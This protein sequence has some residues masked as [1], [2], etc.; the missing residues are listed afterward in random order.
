MVVRPFRLVQTSVSQRVTYRVFYANLSPLNSENFDGSATRRPP[1]SLAMLGNAVHTL[2]VTWRLADKHAKRIRRVWKN[3]APIRSLLNECIQSIVV[4]RVSIALIDIL[5]PRNCME[6]S[7]RRSL[8]YKKS[9]PNSIAA[10][11]EQLQFK[12]PAIG[13]RK[14][15]YRAARKYMPATAFHIL[16]PI[17]RNQTKLKLTNQRHAAYPVTIDGPSNFTPLPC[18]SWTLPTTSRPSI[19][20]ART[21]PR[22][23]SNQREKNNT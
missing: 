11:L 10:S 23:G 20:S 9:S 16:K 8:R 15:T 18:T 12:T 2:Y 14:A 22:P 21:S 13:C 4:C 6:N 1:S 5:R 3:L 7:Y 17:V 19:S